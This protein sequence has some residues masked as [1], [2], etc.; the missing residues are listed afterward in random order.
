[1]MEKFAKKLQECICQTLGSTSFRKDGSMLNQEQKKAVNFLDGK[2]CVIACAGSGKTAVLVNRT[3]VLINQHR[4]SPQKI[5]L[6]SFNRNSKQS[7]QTR[8]AKELGAAQAKQI[9]VNTFHS[10]GYKILLEYSRSTQ[11]T[12]INERKMKR[13]ISD[14]CIGNRL[15]ASP[16]DIDYT[17]ILEYISNKKNHLI[18]PEEKK[19]DSQT[20]LAKNQEY[21]KNI[22]ENKHFLNEENINESNREKWDFIYGKYE[23]YKN[24]NNLL[25]FDDLVYQAALALKSDKTFLDKI[26]TRC[27]YIMIDEAQD[28]NEAQWIL[29]E[30]I[31]N[32]HQNL[33]VVGDPCQNIY[34][35]RGASSNSFVSFLSNIDVQVVRLFRNYRSTHQIVQTANSVMLSKQSPDNA[36]YTPMISMVGD[37]MLP[38]LQSYQTINHEADDIINFIQMRVQ[39]EGDLKYEDIAIIART[40]AQLMAFESKMHGLDIPY[41]LNEGKSL[42]GSKEIQ[43]ILHYISL[44]INPDDNQ[45]FKEIHNIPPRMLGA[46]FLNKT[47]EAADDMHCSYIQA[48]KSLRL[49]KIHQSG[50]NELLTILK[51]VREFIES[52]VTPGLLVEYVR[53][54]INLDDY[55]AKIYTNNEILYEDAQ[56]MI[57]GLAMI[58]LNYNSIDDFLAEMKWMQHTAIQSQNKGVRLITIHQSKGLEF[59]VV[60]VIGVSEGL[61]PHKLGDITEERRL[62][63]VAIT[64]AQQELYFSSIRQGTNGVQLGYSRFLSDI[65]HK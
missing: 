56:A 31:S 1:M 44:A 57:D 50:V 46:S 2:C 14:I 28:M 54:R 33:F 26:S 3:K 7:L 36:I 53:K 49:N 5:I 27:R 43:I 39:S 4:V 30:L 11:F 65:F 37:G 13:I 48:M 52:K 29:A 47:K 6:I 62:L 55:I 22:L 60:F 24:E 23:A 20:I 15:Y 63:Y 17:A 64:R 12:V 25:D 38:I 34:M 58:A 59:P 45:A 40:N 35:W 10:L 42:F 21:I 16:K 8:L 61:L 32:K 51:D 41:H 9:Q 18:Q 19:L